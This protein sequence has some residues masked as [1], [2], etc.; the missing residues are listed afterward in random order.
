VNLSKISEIKP[1]VDVAGPSDLL[2]PSLIESVL[3]QDKSNKP[4]SPLKIP[5]S[6]QVVPDV[7]EDLM[8]LL[9]DISLKLVPSLD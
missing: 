4:E 5:V 1:I 6:V 2:K 8:M 9:G 3:L 7:K